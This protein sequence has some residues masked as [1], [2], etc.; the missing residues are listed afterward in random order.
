MDELIPDTS[1][2]VCSTAGAASWQCPHQAEPNSNTSGPRVASIWS[3]VGPGFC[4][5]LAFYGE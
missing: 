3:R 5:R 4:N 1:A 2:S